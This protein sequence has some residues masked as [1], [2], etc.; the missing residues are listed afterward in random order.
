MVVLS[1]TN[2]ILDKHADPPMHGSDAYLDKNGN[3]VMTGGGG[4]YFTKQAGENPPGYLRMG[5][6]SCRVS[7]RDQEDLQGDSKKHGDLAGVAVR[8]RERHR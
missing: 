3:L 4:R 8:H 5:R 1:I 7:G 6:T 2:D